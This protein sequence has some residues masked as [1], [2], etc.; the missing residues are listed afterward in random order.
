MIR[1]WDGVSMMRI[2]KGQVKYKDRSDIIC[3]YGINDDGKQYYFLDGEKLSNGNLVASTALV[4]AIDPLVVASNIGVISND[5]EIVVPFENKA[6]KPI[7]TNAILVEKAIPST[8]SVIDAIGM[9]SD[10]LAATKLVTTP[11]TIKEKMNAKMGFGGR[12]I[13]NDQ[14]SEASVF[15][16]DGENLLDNQ[17]YS[18]I[19]LNHN[20]LYMSKNV[21]DSEIVEYSF[22]GDKDDEKAKSDE[23]LDVQNVKVPADIVDKAIEDSDKVIDKVIDKKD[24]KFFNHDVEAEKDKEDEKGEEVEPKLTE[25]QFHPVNLQVIEETPK[26]FSDSLSIKEKKIEEPK[27]DSN[28]KF[29]K[30]PDKETRVSLFEGLKL[31]GDS[32]GELSDDTNLIEDAAS[33]ISKLIK[34]NKEQREKLENYEDEVNDLILFKRQAFSENQKLSKEADALKKRIEKL[35]AELVTKNEELEKLTAQ[36]A[37]KDDLV[38]LLADAQNLLDE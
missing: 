30:N 32:S 37:G 11:A 27:D 12:F 24:N 17:Y 36:V 25:S 14:F 4:E 7:L 1:I 34:K 29:I 15:D 38:K 20:K 21:V 22:D 35:E 13:F 10:P 16:L 28:N 5:G 33:T 23:L 26:E 8:Q 2:Q 3:T 9:R 31:D 18:F 6:I 19:G